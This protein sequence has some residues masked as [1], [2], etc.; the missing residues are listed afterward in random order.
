MIILENHT[1][2]RVYD[3]LNM[4]EICYVEFKTE[5]NE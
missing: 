3:F 4:K 1:T 5:P 2:M